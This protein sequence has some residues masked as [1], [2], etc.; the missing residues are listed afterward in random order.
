MDQTRNM[1][2]FS[3]IA[4]ISGPFP[5]SLATQNTLHD[6]W[7][8][9]IPFE[10]VDVLLNRPLSIE[11]EDIN[12]KLLHKRRGGYCFEYNS[13]FKQIL[14]EVEFAVSHQ[15]GRVVWGRTNSLPRLRHICC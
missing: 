8:R 9:T 15:L 7:P 6:G 13:F 14:E 3:T 10:N 5:A 12:D 2:L 1:P 4:G 11:L